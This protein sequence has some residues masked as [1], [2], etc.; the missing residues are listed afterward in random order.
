MS[1][2]SRPIYGHGISVQPSFKLVLQT[3]SDMSRP[4]YHF[5]LD[6]IYLGH[7]SVE[8]IRRP[9]NMI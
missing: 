5:A 2:A 3:L 4:I 7:M 9:I 6:T 1:G 8:E